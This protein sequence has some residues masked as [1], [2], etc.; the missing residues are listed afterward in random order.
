ME[1]VTADLLRRISERIVESLH[2]EKIVLFGS[3]AW[4]TPHQESDV[5]LLVVVSTSDEPPYKRARAVYRSL[6]DI[7]VPLDV[8]VQTHDEMERSLRVSSSL[9]HKVMEE[10]MVLYG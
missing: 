6:R 1:K 10:G 7:T 2:P 9:T 3:H 5:D 8:V 4:G